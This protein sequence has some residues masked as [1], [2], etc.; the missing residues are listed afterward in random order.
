MKRDLPIKQGTLLIVHMHLE[1]ILTHT[2][3]TRSVM[4]ACD[5]QHASGGLYLRSLRLRSRFDCTP[6]QQR[7]P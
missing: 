4:D 2:H 7:F 6:T 3:W 1:M 5:M